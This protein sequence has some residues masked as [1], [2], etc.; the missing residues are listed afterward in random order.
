MNLITKT[1]FLTCVFL[2]SFA[3][4]EI[5]DVKIEVTLRCP[6]SEELQNLLDVLP[7]EYS[8]M[9]FEIWKQNYLAVLKKTME[10]V[11]S[12]KV[13]SYYWSTSVQDVK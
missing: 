4:A 12:G 7:K 13:G 9:D 1:A 3:N 6:P 11:E 10:L 8:D 2:A 5:K